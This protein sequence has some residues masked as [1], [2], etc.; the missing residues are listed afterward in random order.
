MVDGDFYG[1]HVGYEL[2]MGIVGQ[3]LGGSVQVRNDHGG[4][5]RVAFKM[6]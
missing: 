5:V 6:E 1:A 3:N 2:I 4:I